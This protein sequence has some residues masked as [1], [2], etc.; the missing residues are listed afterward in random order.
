MIIHR[1]GDGSEGYQ[2]ELGDEVRIRGVIASGEWFKRV[3]GRIGQVVDFDGPTRKPREWRTDALHVRE[4]PDFG[5]S[6]CK[7][8]HIE[9]TA[10][11]LARAS[12]IDVVDPE[13]GNPWSEDS[14]DLD[15]FAVF[16][17]EAMEKIA[18]DEVTL[19]SVAREYA[20]SRRLPLGFV[21]AELSCALETVG[22]PVATGLKP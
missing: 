22:H 10:A 20:G 12:V 5:P 18:N 16:L 9:P 14:V 15:A 13:N 6:L 8:W 7:P 2:Y 17:S 1:H 4:N 21:V 19:E 3:I 11:T